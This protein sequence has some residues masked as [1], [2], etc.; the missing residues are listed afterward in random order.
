MLTHSRIHSCPLNVREEI[1]VSQT[2]DGFIEAVAVVAAQAAAENLPFASW[3]LVKPV[4]LVD[5]VIAFQWQTVNN[6]SAVRPYHEYV[7]IARATHSDAHE[8]MPLEP[9]TNVFERSEQQVGA[10]RVQHWA[11]GAWL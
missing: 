2:A 3:S 7:L 6:G 4:Y 9:P 11:G 10:H 5:P 1:Q 8:L